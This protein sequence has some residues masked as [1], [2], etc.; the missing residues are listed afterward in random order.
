MAAQRVFVPAPPFPPAYGRAAT[1]AL[2]LG[3]F[4]GFLTGLYALGVPAFGWPAQAF[5]P[6]VQAH[7]QIQILG[8]AGLLILG[9]GGLLLPG[10]WRAKLAHPKALATGGWLVGIGLLAQLLGQPWPAGPLRSVLLAVAAVLPPLGFLWA[11]R[12]LLAARPASAGRPVAWEW[13]LLLAATSLAGTL[14]LRAISLLTLAWSGQPADYGLA[15]QLLVALELDGFLLA[16]TIGV[17]LRLLPPLA[18]TRPVTGWVQTVGIGALALAVLAR[19]LGIGL[20]LPDL[21]VLGNWLAV[22]A[23]LA[24]FWA[25]GLGRRGIPPTVQAA[26]TLLPGRTRLVLRVVWAGLLVSV[27]GRA[28]GLLSADTTTHAFTTIYLVPLILVVGVRMLP[29]ISAYPIRFPVLCGALV[30]AGVAGGILRAFGGLAT[31]QLGAQIG[32]LG[33]GVLTTVLLVFVAL[34]W[35]PWGV[36]TGVPRTPEIMQIDVPKKS[37][38]PAP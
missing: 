30:W 37:T 5:G 19:M 8:F 1:I 27:L 26:A 15:H 16:A 4:G 2:A 25:T 13:L 32:W 7:G 9:V 35:S 17:Q 18:R 11:G 6:L 14:L 34:A 24:L 33:G 29:R 21:A 28:S 23:V 38:A 31:G 20:V 36:P 12:Q 3:L 10:F 22:V